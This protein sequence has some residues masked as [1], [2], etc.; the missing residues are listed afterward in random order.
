M[1]LWRLVTALGTAQLYFEDANCHHFLV[2][3][4]SVATDARTRY[5]YAF[6]NIIPIRDTLAKK[7]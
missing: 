4:A 7:K 6:S 5:N 1:L 2:Q 3:F